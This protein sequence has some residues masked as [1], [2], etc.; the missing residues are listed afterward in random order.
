M[1]LQVEWA[2]HQDPYITENVQVNRYVNCNTETGE[3]P[4]TECHTEVEKMLR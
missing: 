4:T 1:M 2:A 3:I